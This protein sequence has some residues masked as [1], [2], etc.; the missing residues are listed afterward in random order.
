VQVRDALND[1]PRLGTGRL[2]LP[3][4][5]AGRSLD[6]LFRVEAKQGDPIR[7]RLAWDD[8]S[9]E[10]HSIRASFDIPGVPQ[11]HTVQEDPRVIHVREHLLL[12]R[13]QR[14]VARLADIGDVGGAMILLSG[15]KNRLLVEGLRS[16]INM[17]TELEQVATLEQRLKRGEHHA[18]SKLARKQSYD[19][20]TGREER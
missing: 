13:T 15:V 8:H 2:A 10:R 3:P 12:A 7:L 19:K 9:G 20:T 1:L 11:A 4:L 14:E 6:L 16:G 5:R 18:A 17:Q